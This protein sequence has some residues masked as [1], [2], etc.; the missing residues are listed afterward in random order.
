MRVWSNVGGRIK[1]ERCNVPGDPHFH[2]RA[3]LK[4]G[5]VQG[6]TGRRSRQKRH[7]VLQSDAGPFLHGKI[8][9]ANHGAVVREKMA[10]ITTTPQETMEKVLT[11]KPDLSMGRRADCRG[12]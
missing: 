12:G 9:G 8:H 4:A 10:H 1:R 2:R 7:V 5:G 6:G 3:S 11:K